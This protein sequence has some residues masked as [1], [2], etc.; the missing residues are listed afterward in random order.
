MK[1]LRLMQK[2]HI[3]SP[4]NFR[5]K[6]KIL[7]FPGNCKFHCGTFTLAHPVVYLCAICYQVGS[8][9][10]VTVIYTTHHR[11]RVSLHAEFI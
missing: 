2:I 3:K 7:S 6:I 8:Q 11:G 4:A 1:I 10:G 9:L 5:N